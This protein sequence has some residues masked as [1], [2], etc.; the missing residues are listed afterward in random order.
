MGIGRSG[1]LSTREVR[2]V[3]K[4]KQEQDLFHLVDDLS[5]LLD[6]K[7]FISGALC[8]DGIVLYLFYRSLVRLLQVGKEG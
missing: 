6:D 3:A 5:Y 7:R 2:K 8:P 4:H 1:I